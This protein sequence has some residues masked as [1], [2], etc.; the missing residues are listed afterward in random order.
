[1]IEQTK[2]LQSVIYCNLFQIIELAIE[3]G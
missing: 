2:A 1:M 3:G